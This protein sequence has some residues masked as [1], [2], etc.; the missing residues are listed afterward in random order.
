MTSHHLRCAFMKTLLFVFPYVG[1]VKIGSVDWA[2]LIA[3]LYL[4]RRHFFYC[5]PSIFGI[6]GYE[7]IYL[8]FFTSYSQKPVT[9][10]FILLSLVH[11]LFGNLYFWS[12]MVH[13]DPWIWLEAR[14]SQVSFGPIGPNHSLDQC[15]NLSS[16]KQLGL[17]SLR[18]HALCWS[19]INQ[20]WRYSGI[21]L[22][23]LTRAFGP[24]NCVVIVWFRTWFHLLQIQKW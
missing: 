23:F 14:Q 10:T 19:L 2:H 1:C 11:V 9:I 21:A 22:A 8:A 17:P 4:C 15:C 6:K 3:G 5:F 12:M 20:G 18:L 7:F 13:S 16:E 24:V